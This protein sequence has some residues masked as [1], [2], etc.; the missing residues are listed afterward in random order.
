MRIVI[1]A[2]SSF[3]FSSLDRI[4]WRVILL[5]KL[6]RM[7]RKSSDLLNLNVAMLEMNPMLVLAHHSSKRTYV[8]VVVILK[9][10]MQTSI[11]ESFVITDCSALNSIHSSFEDIHK[12]Y[13]KSHVVISQSGFLF[14]D[15]KRFFFQILLSRVGTKCATTLLFLEYIRSLGCSKSQ[16]IRP[17]G[18]APLLSVISDVSFCLTQRREPLSWY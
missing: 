1:W 4:D 7:F 9:M 18:P 2:L 15:F 3:L 6:M 8:I 12:S 11:Q 10:M 14:P 13:V 5:D 16:L 17:W